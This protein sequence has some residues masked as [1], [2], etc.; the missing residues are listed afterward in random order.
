MSRLDSFFWT[1]CDASVRIGAMS[2]LSLKF[3]K[4]CS[5]AV[6]AIAFWLGGIG[7]AFC[8]ATMAAEACCPEESITS[9]VLSPSHDESAHACCQIS[10]VRSASSQG[11]ALSKREG[12]RVCA[13][14]PSDETSLALIPHVSDETVSA[15]GNG[16]PVFASSASVVR[17]EQVYLHPP[18][19]DDTY[20][21]CCA[22]LI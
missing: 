16:L 8:C 14:L 20:L 7:C 21:K 22:L 17:P 5:L 10:P 15:S 11:N 6:A 9:K 13:L 4:S 19:R 2:R 18:G 1:T 3:K 12:L